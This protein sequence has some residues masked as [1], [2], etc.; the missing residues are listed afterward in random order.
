[1]GVIGNVLMNIGLSIAALSVWAI[2]GLFLYRKE[3]RSKTN[4]AYFSLYVSLDRLSDSLSYIKE[5]LEKPMSDIRERTNE[6]KHNEIRLER[7][8]NVFNI[9]WLV[10]NLPYMTKDRKLI[11]HC[12][13]FS[14]ASRKLNNSITSH[15]IAYNVDIYFVMSR[16]LIEN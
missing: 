12:E 4:L 14:L 16:I 5:I 15:H 6:L 11:Y 7:T 10:S 3:K 9:T 13:L 8:L 1:V 2:V